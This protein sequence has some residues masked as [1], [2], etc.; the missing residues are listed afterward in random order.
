MARLGSHLLAL[1]VG[2]LCGALGAASYLR[3]SVP[4]QE[5]PRAPA[6]TP[7]GGAAASTAQVLDLSIADG[8]LYTVR[9]VVD[10]DTLVLENGLHVRYQGVNA[11]EMGR[12][13]RKAAPLGEEAKQRNEALLAGKRVRL[14]LG[15]EPLDAYGRLI[16]RVRAVGEDGTETDL[17]TILL[18]EG[19]G[20]AFGKGLPREAYDALK[21]AQQRAQA[22][23]LGLWG[24]PHPLEQG[25]PEGYRYCASS[26]SDVYHPV[27]SAT[28]R[29]IV[30]GNFIGFKSREE[31]EASGRR[32]AK[33]AEA[34]ES[35]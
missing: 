19:L 24:L 2:L 32:P 35:E 29:R 13:I 10:G 6:S 22:A 23:G 11:P 30:A 8:G 16:A 5:P 1:G 20:R 9:R 3:G 18:E 31:A 12:F 34:A 33:G 17:E 21:A 4:A 7:L 15:P 26:G 28:A 27:E 25:N 14:M